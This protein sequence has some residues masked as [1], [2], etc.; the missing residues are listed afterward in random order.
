MMHSFFQ[1]SIFTYILK[2]TYILRR[3]LDK[4]ARVE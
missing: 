2:F 1:S 4:T 3:I